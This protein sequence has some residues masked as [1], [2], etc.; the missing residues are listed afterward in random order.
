VS[1]PDI[2]YC[3]SHDTADRLVLGYSPELINETPADEIRVVR[4]CRDLRF[5]WFEDDFLEAGSWQ[6][7]VNDADD[8]YFFA[9]RQHLRRVIGD[10]ARRVSLGDFEGSKV[11][12]EVDLGQAAVGGVEGLLE[13]VEL[14]QVHRLRSFYTYI[15]ITMIT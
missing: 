14:F 6:C 9:D 3:Q 2:A 5:S 13:I 10:P 12:F 7:L 8:G 15:I 1:I 11:S 4:G